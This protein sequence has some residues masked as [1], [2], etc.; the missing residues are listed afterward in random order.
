MPTIGWQSDIHGKMNPYLYNLNIS[1]DIYEGY[2]SK[3]FSHM[4][5]NSSSVA[6]SVLQKYIVSDKIIVF[7]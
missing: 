5:T 1:L 6:S 4:V 3:I 2:S 7:N